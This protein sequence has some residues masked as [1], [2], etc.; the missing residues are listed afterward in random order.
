MSAVGR[1]LAIVLV[2]HLAALGGCAGTETR[3]EAQ[4]E[5][6][7][8]LSLFNRGRFSEAASRLESV[9]CVRLVVR[10]EGTC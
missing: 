10:C 8:G 6:D 2:A 9:S 3:D 5:F 7:R 4:G 1:I